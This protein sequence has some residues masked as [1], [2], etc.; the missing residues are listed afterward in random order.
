MNELP[1]VTEAQ[2]AQPNPWHPRSPTPSVRL[3][4]PTGKHIVKAK[5]R[6]Y[7]VPHKGGPRT[8]VKTKAGA[9]RLKNDYITIKESHL[10]GDIC[11]VLLD[12]PSEE[13]SDN[14]IYPAGA[15]F[16]IPQNTERTDQEQLPIPVAASPPRSALP[17]SE[18][19]VQIWDHT[20]GPPLPDDIAPSSPH[21]APMELDEPQAMVAPR[22][23]TPTPRASSRCRS[24]SPR[25]PSP[26][27]TRRPRSPDRYARSSSYRPRSLPRG[28]TYERGRRETYYSRRGMDSYVPE[29]PT[30]EQALQDRS[31]S[32]LCCQRSTMLSSHGVLEDRILTHPPSLNLPPRSVTPSSVSSLSKS[33]AVSGA[34]TDHAPYIT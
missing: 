8:L 3:A 30:R 22:D 1:W 6:V 15:N 7:T 11:I 4:P 13:D 20:D 21:D 24:W 10:D 25:R 5:E 14:D 9:K 31:Q 2:S 23:P 29:H 26:S 17:M 27:S 12:H 28:R 33:S 32:P 34:P 16:N 18:N 19:E